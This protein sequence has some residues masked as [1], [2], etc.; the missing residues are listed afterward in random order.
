MLSPPLYFDAAGE[1]ILATGAK[2]PT[3]TGV[4]AVAVEVPLPKVRVAVYVPFEP[5]E[6]PGF[7]LVETGD[8]SPKS[9]LK[10]SAWPYDRSNR[11]TRTE[12]SAAPARTQ[13]L[14]TQ[15]QSGPASQWGRSSI[16]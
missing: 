1:V 11:P 5:Y 15:R 3:T 10:V 4:V 16:T 2:L 7:G 9:Q 8:P 14:P 6:W 13:G 12:R